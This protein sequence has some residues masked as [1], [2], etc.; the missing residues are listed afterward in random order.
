MDQLTTIIQSVQNKLKDIE[1]KG[2]INIS[3]DRKS[4]YTYDQN[5]LELTE[6]ISLFEKLKTEFINYIKTSSNPKFSIITEKDFSDIK[7]STFYLPD[8]FQNLILT[9]EYLKHWFLITIQLYE[10][11]N[12]LKNILR[13]Y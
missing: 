10:Y 3:Y 8:V 6:M 11:I 13:S 2:Y 5:E 4:N 9:D 7:E 1:N 12:I